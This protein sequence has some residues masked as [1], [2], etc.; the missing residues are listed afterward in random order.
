M[1]G[2]DCFSVDYRAARARFR[3]MA[4][5]R[6][7]RQESHPVGEVGD[8]TVDVAFGGDEGG[9][10]RVIVSSGVHGVEGFLGSAIQLGLL[11][12]AMSLPPGVGLVLV[13][14]INPSG[15][16]GLR[17][18]DEGNVD[19]NRNF[20]LDG[21]PY[22]GSPPMYGVL[23]RVLN[24]RRPP[25]WPD[26]FAI[27]ALG[28]IARHGIAGPR[29]AIAGGQYDYPLGLF[30][31]GHGPTASHRLL[32][33]HLPRWAGGA[34]RVI[35]LDVHSGLGP[36][37][38][39]AL[40]LDDDLPAHRVGR[41]SR[42]FDG[43]KV[44]WAGDRVAFPTRGGLGSWCGSVF[45]GREYDYL[46]AEFG[47]YSGLKVLASLRAENQ[48]YHWGRPGDPATARAR[49]RLVESFAPAD[50]GWRARAVASGLEL[51]RRAFDVVSS[52]S[53]PRDRSN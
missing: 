10:G 30:F 5:A 34:D 20:L 41:I 31:G 28:P 15:F 3:S 21:Q 32:A 44:E 37:A 33:G 51:V 6:G 43:F 46:C 23:D 27:E 35:H 9:S 19:L 45:E 36:W 49:R 13:H 38:S 29:R 16:S 8:L 18:W 40:L 25:R 47:T 4:A 14:A 52:R 1:N 17:R 42:D 48:A 22:S 50:L 53:G 2:P 7:F 11:D 39:L 12:E 24:P 26:L